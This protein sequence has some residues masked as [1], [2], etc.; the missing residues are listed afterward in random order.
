MIGPAIG[1]LLSSGSIHAP[2]WAAASLSALSLTLTFI[3]LPREVKH[4]RA[5]EHSESFPFRSIW[6][7]FHAPTTSRIAWLMTAFYFALSTYMSGQAL[8]LAGRFTWQGHPFNPENI[9]LVFTYI[10]AINIFVQMFLMKRLTSFFSEEKLLAAGFLLMGIGF[11]GVGLCLAVTPLIAFLTIANI[12]ASI[13]RPLILSQLS[14]RVP[15]GKQG[16]V[17]G[18]NQ[19]IYSVCA[20]LAP[21]MSG[22]LINRAFYS[23]WAWLIALLGSV[24][25][26][27]AFAL[28]PNSTEDC[29]LF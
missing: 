1:G 24:G 29:H 10:A 22:A 4:D 9:G 11:A 2:L 12:G 16:L 7:T 17:M 6:A 15:A 18:V 23:S 14:K 26:L 3:L 21:L 28:K 13:L 8:F 19:S 25:L 5:H 27:I 20:I